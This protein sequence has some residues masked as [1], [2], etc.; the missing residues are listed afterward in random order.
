MVHIKTNLIVRG[1]ADFSGFK[2]EFTKAQA[3]MKTFQTQ[4]GA[5]GQTCA[6]MGTMIKAAFALVGVGALVKFGNESIKLASD[7]Q[8]VQNVVDTAFGDMA[9]KMEEFAKKSIETYGL[10]K[11]AA[12]QT[13]SSYMAMA[14]GMKL[15][16]KQASEMALTLTGLSADM[17]SFYNIDQSEAKTALSSIFTGETE[18]L[19]R[20][21]ILITEV[22]LQEFARQKGI[23]KSI[24]AMTQQE[25]V[26]LRYNYVMEATKL[27]QGD[28]AKTSDSWANQTRILSERWKEFKGVIG[29][30]L[31]QAF[32]PVLK[33]INT[34]IER[35]TVFANY[36]N[37]VMAA[38]FGRQK[39]SANTS[40]DQ[41]NAIGDSVKNQNKLTNAV[42]G[43]AKANQ[44]ALAGFDELNVLTQK[45]ADSGVGGV[46]SSISDDILTGGSTIGDNVEVSPKIYKAIEDV[47]SLFIGLSDFL[48]PLM[49]ELTYQITKAFK[50]M[51]EEGIK[52]FA[53]RTATIIN[54]LMESFA[55]G[56]GKWG[57]PIFE[58]IKQAFK[59][60][61]SIW[62]TVWSSALKPLW[63]EFMQI[64]DWLWADHLKPLTDNFID[65]I[66]ELVNGAL[67]IYNEFITP[68]VTWLIEIFGPVFVNIYKLISNIIGT[69]LATFIDFKSSIITVL[70]G[71]IQFIVGVF[72]G[73][74]GK[75]WDGVRQIFKGV[76]DAFASIVKG[77]VN[78]V[79]DFVNHMIRLVATGL[80]FV[81]DAA[82]TISFDIPEWL[83]GG[84]F[85]FNIPNV[86]PY[87]IPKLANGAVIQP[88]SE[89]LAVLGDQRQG[90]NIETP[91]DTMIQAFKTALGDNGASNGNTTLILELDNREFGRAV[92]NANRNE[93][94]RIGTRLVT[95]NG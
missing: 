59:S 76:W 69:F 18:T 62:S 2:K 75:A 78:T 33:V 82:N 66:G 57:M 81:I 65:F 29:N 68:V 32:T 89:F 36:F 34:V 77:V 28:F 91:L 85:G 53:T 12:K 46:D 60:T 26:M 52:P 15:A 90:V 55:A 45:N 30:G 1:G 14:M 94:Q 31:I 48:K 40:K 64:V 39:N 80:N 49:L 6:K 25:K 22:N 56:W 38:L 3:Q 16:Q 83:G 54:D 87:Q 44:K 47:K 13:G 37:Q 17:A 19:K 67:R 72:T 41:S 63:E 10:S 71:I 8:E 4:T 51:H 11:L 93:T 58:N 88:N 61:G 27:A 20:Y 21:G 70:K 43:T 5:I 35:L 84:T 23:R 50:Q 79:I 24:S 7:M 95:V 42:N 74:W 92:F 86:T 73:E 9:Y